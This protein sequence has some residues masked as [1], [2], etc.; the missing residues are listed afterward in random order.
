MTISSAV[1]VKSS[2]EHPVLAAIRQL[3][4]R[5]ATRSEEIETARRLPAYLA[6][7]LAQAGVFRMVVPEAY[8]GLELHPALI[9][10][11][12]ETLSRADGSAGWCG[13]IGSLTAICSAWLPE[14]DAR[15]I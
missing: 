7:E 6:L 1:A 4:P 10:E 12:L 9:V 15:L 14:A 2:G 3:A 5:V 8:G 11:A 13:M